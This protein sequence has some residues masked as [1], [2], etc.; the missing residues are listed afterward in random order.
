MRVVFKVTTFMKSTLETVKS[1]MVS[2]YTNIMKYIKI[3]KCYIYRFLVGWF[4]LQIIIESTGWTT[5]ILISEILKVERSRLDNFYGLSIFIVVL[6][7]EF[8][9]QMLVLVLYILRC[10]IDTYNKYSIYIRFFIVVLLGYW[11][12]IMEFNSYHP[13]LGPLI[14][15]HPYQTPFIIVYHMIHIALYICALYIWN[16]FIDN[17]NSKP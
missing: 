17:R 5:E 6:L 12:Y 13:V 14:E 8:M 9:L 2:I 15:D 16:R 3:N 1:V 11:S 4:I 10:N 7:P